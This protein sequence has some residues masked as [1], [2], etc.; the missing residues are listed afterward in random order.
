[1][2]DDWET[3]FAQAAGEIEVDATY[4]EDSA[5]FKQSVS[6]NLPKSKDTAKDSNSNLVLKQKNSKEIKKKKHK[7]KRRCQQIYYVWPDFL[8]LGSTFSLP[9]S[10]HSKCKRYKHRRDGSEKND[11]RYSSCSRC[12]ANPMHHQL[13]LKMVLDGETMKNI[14][15]YRGSKQSE[16]GMRRNEPILRYHLCEMFVKNRNIRCLSKL[17]IDQFFPVRINNIA[18]SLRKD[19]SMLNNGVLIKGEVEMLAEKVHFLCNNLRNWE[20]NSESG[21]NLDYVAHVVTSSDALYYRLYYL[22][23]SLFDNN[24]NDV[25][26]SIPEPAHYFSLDGMAWDTK[27]GEKIWNQYL[28]FFT[29]KM[30][31]S[32][33]QT[34]FV[35]N[36]NTELDFFGP[37]DD[38]NNP[39]F[40]LYC[41]RIKEMIQMFWYTKWIDHQSIQK[42]HLSS[43]VALSLKNVDDE[44]PAAHS[45]A[46]WRDSARDYACNIYAYATIPPSTIKCI[47]SWVKR[48]NLTV[49][50]IGAGT[51][52]VAYLLRQVGISIQ[53][54]DISPTCVEN[55]SINEY[56]GSCPSFTDVKYGNTSTLRNLGSITKSALLLCYPP[57][58]S[59]MALECLTYFVEA[60][61]KFLI[62]IGEFGGLTGS[63]EF[64]SKL[65][66]DFVCTERY[67]MPSW[68]TD[69]SHVTLWETRCDDKSENT[70]SRYKLLNP[71]SKCGIKESIRRFAFLRSIVYCSGECF[72]THVDERSRLLLQQMISFDALPL[73]L[74]NHLVFENN[75]CCIPLKPVLYNERKRLLKKRMRK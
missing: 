18:E 11:F 48:E 22:Q 19:C 8:E 37:T 62:H 4:L 54:F 73:S 58:A 46:T 29:N 65:V 10:G 21:N 23:I 63:N 44:T 55:N 6:T 42:E 28:K 35:Q 7:Q 50:E 12:G 45:L 5:N 67:E 39:L 43:M 38:F 57:P 68:G 3:L 27:D 1:M 56:H 36:L 24:F 49:V 16:K 52:Y 64:E 9:C 59:S 60:G 53:A 40:V 70:E 33:T 30:D 34:Y 41:S 75:A 25:S 51:G 17:S 26:P 69:A 14:G 15:N 66:T 32:L 2:N 72:K 13:S 61:G 31:K 20:K 71:C 47:E 74:K